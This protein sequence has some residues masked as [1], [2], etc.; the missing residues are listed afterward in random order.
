MSAIKN[1]RRYIETDEIYQ[2]Y[3]K[4]K[5]PAHNDG[6]T[7]FEWFCINH[8][9]DIETVLNH[10]K[11]LRDEKNTLMESLFA[12]R[13]KWNNN[14]AKYRRKAKKYRYIIKELE[15]WIK[16]TIDTINKLIIEEWD[17]DTKGYL[18]ARKF[19]LK[20]VLEKINEYRKQSF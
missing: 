6:S 8:C 15:K 14:K 3:K 1:L 10:N 11:K 12:V 17:E 2:N 16:E 5:E 4:G 18:I 20:E 19:M 7:D 13:T 9:K